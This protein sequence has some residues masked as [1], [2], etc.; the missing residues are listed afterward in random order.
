M[1]LSYIRKSYVR[2][3]LKSVS[4][5]LII[6]NHEMSGNIVYSTVWD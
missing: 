5:E 2:Q 6:V 1:D 3:I 4:P